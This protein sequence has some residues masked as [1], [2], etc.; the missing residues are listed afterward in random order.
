MTSALI[1]PKLQRLA[2]LHLYLILEF[3]SS[4]VAKR[5]QITFTNSP[6]RDCG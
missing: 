3:K 6:N 2:I 4:G 1:E 5:L